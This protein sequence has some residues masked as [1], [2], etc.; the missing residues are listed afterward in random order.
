MVPSDELTRVAAL[1]PDRGDECVLVGIDGVDGAGKTTFADALA[2][3]VDRPVVR[4][5]VDDFHQVESIRYRRGRDSAKGFW[6][7]AFD[8]DRVIADVLRPLRDG[9]LYRPAAHDVR[10][11]EVLD[12]AWET[13]PPGAVVIVDGLFLQ[14]AELADLFD[15]HVYLD[16][17]FEIAAER[18]R[19]RDGDRSLERYVGASLIYFAECDPLRRADLVIDNR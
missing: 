3:M 7:D 6:L 15:F 2:R 18:L 16:V 12:P 19:E 13:A 4:I 8:Y 9:R 5:S 10:T 1:I 14:R 17:P 11:D